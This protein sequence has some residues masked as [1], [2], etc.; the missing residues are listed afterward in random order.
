MTVWRKTREPEGAARSVATLEPTL[1]QW[2]SQVMGD[3][4]RVRTAESRLASSMGG[5]RAAVLAA[6][7]ELGV[8]TREAMMWL[9]ENPRRDPS[10]SAK[11]ARVLKA[12]TA[13]ERAAHEIAAYPDLEPQQARNRLRDLISVVDFQSQKLNAW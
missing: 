3:L 11:V 5:G 4:E 1:M 8:A 7:E 6:A 12:Y 2:R 10:L 9:A 13:L